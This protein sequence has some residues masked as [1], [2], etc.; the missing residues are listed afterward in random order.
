VAAAVGSGVEVGSS[1]VGSGALT[2][3]T[4]GVGGGASDAGPAVGN[5]VGKAPSEPQAVNKNAKSSRLSE[6]LRIVLDRL[7]HFCLNVV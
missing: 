4:G 2:A 6:I 3:V 5:R 1:G 7:A